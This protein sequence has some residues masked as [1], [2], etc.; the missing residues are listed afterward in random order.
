MLGDKLLNLR[1]N[2]QISQEEFSQLLN[3]SRQAVSK[4]ER[5]EARPDIDK[6][7]LIAKLFNVSLDYLLDQE[8]RHCDIDDYINKINECYKSNKFIININDIKLLIT[9]YPNNFKLHIYSSGYLYVAFIS[10]NQY[11]YLDLALSCIKKAIILY[12][13][14][15]SDIASLNDLHKS[16]CEIY[17]MKGNFKKAKEYAEKNNV[18]E[19]DV[20]LSK[21]DFSLK[22]YDEALKRASN[23][24]L[25]SISDIMNVTLIQIM[26]LLKNKNIKEAFDLTNWSISFI[27]SVQ[28]NIEFTKFVL[29][30]FIYLKAACEKLLNYDNKESINM[31]KE[32]SC[33]S[34]NDNIISDTK[35]LKYYFGNVDSKLLID[36]NIE[37]ALKEIIK[38]TSK[39]DI[40]YQVL[41]DIYNEVFGG[42][43]SE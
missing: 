22:N 9:K 34:F 1:K 30:P 11:E 32:F 8:I 10:N 28:K 26:I 37:S 35:S 19:C 36:S 39:T 12:I 15:Y 16:V 43:I 41:V 3:T 29:C 25:K 5:N 23:I 4:W 40:H 17:L 7:I 33:S 6:L 24:Y 38:K 20:L 42:V 18:Y 13:P 27:N 2:R 14:E 21:C 31:I